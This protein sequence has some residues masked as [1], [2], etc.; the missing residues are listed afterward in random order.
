[1]RRSMSTRAVTFLAVAL[2]FVT[3]VLA[4]HGVAWYDYSKTVTAK[5][6]TVTQFD[7]TNPH[8]N[9]RF[10]V[11]DDKHNVAHWIV[12]MH[13]PDNM[14]EHGWT[15]QTLR[16]GDVVTITFRP[17]KNG[18]ASGLLEDVVLP[19]GIALRQNLLLLPAGQTM[20]VEEWTR[21]F[22]RKVISNPP[23]SSLH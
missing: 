11:T 23:A 8:C 16:P 19:N 1:M 15:R 2:G 22:G 6:V 9:I 12:E 10:D 18:S 7:W 3:P 21:R 20:S 4:H 5:G 14:I 17:S 13:P